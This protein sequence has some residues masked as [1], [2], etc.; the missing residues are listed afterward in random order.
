LFVDARANDVMMQALHKVRE[1]CVICAIYLFFLG[2]VIDFTETEKYPRPGGA[3]I[4]SR[5]GQRWQD[6]LTET[7]GI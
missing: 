1:H 2:F 3:D 6:Y 7:V 5:V 4:A